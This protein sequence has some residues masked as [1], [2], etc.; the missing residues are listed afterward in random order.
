MEH[1]NV[2]YKYEWMPS[3]RIKLLDAKQR[4]YDFPLVGRWLAEHHSLAGNTLSRKQCREL[5]R[6]LGRDDRPPHKLWIMLNRG[7]VMRAFPPRKEA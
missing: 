7:D 1:R 5:W 3:I 4:E 6:W 2:Q